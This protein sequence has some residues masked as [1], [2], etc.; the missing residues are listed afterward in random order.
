MIEQ[1]LLKAGIKNIAGVDEAGRGPCAGPLVL[2]SVILKDPLS[3]ALKEVRDSKEL[4]E[5]K[6]E[7]LFDVVIDNSLAYSIIEVSVDEIDTIGLHKCNIEG[8]RRAINA[9]EVTPDYVLTDG[10]PIPGLTTP[11]LAVWKGDQVAISISAASIL[12]KVY[13]D[14]I[15]IK[16][17]KEFPK[18]GLANH[19]GYITASHTAAIKEFGVLPIHRKSFANIAAIL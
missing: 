1:T 11:N 5:A 7:E 13:R 10:Y 3:K 14:R 4:S 17:D 6:R 8:M 15:M 12:A 2:A 18:Y 9:L 16:L 19:K